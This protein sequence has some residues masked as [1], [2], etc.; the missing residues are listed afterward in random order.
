MPIKDL[1]PSSFGSKVLNADMSQARA[2]NWCFTDFSLNDPSFDSE[3]MHYLKYQ[4]ELCPD[5]DRLHIQGYVQFK[6]QV[7]FNGAK[8]KIS[9]TAHIE[10]AR[11]TPQENAEYC[12]KEES[13]VMGPIEHGE[14]KMTNQGKRTDIRD[15]LEAITTKRKWSDV[16]LDPEIAT[17]ISSRMKWAKEVYQASRTKPICDI[18]LWKWQAELEKE[19]K[20]NPDSRKIIW[21]YDEY[22]NTG[23]STMARW[24]VANTDT[25]VTEGK[26]ADVLYGYQG[27]RIVIFDLSRSTE[28][29]TPYDT[30]E[31]LKNGVY[32][33]TKYESGM[34]VYDQPHVVVFANFEPDR[35]KMS[36]DRWDVRTEFEQ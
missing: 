30:I 25:I 10:V 5:T 13:R 2:R 32:F 4:V 29:Y 8:A 36:A 26:K 17:A 27:E 33:N 22:G 14:I 23:K 24:L 16:I 1:A 15:A 31:K 11:G 35:T 3:S 12:G 6:E 34:R 28:E 9:P 19:L 21:Y 18:T 7:R 20:G